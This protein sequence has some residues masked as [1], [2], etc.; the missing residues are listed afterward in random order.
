MFSPANGLLVVADDGLR[1]PLDLV[2]A[3]VDRL[4][5]LDRAAVGEGGLPAEELVEQNAET[6]PVY[7]MVVT[8]VFSNSELERILF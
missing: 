3:L 4:V 2:D 6:P 1:P 8:Y 7:R 5:D